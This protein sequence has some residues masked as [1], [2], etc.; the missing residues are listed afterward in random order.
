MLLVVLLLA[1]CTNVAEQTD[2]SKNPNPVNDNSITSEVNNPEFEFIP[3]YKQYFEYISKEPSS[4]KERDEYFLDLVVKPL[5]NEIYGDSLSIYPDELFFSPPYDIEKLEGYLSELENQHTQI[6]GYLKG[7]LERANEHLPGGNYR[8]FLLPFNPDI[9]SSYMNGVQG[10]TLETG[11]IVLQIDPNIYSKTSLSWLVTH[12]YHHA[13]YMNISDY[14]TRDYHLLDHVIMEGKADIFTKI[15]YPDY[16]VPWIEP[17]KPNKSELVLQFITENRGSYDFGNVYKLR[18][19]SFEDGLPTWSN[20][21]ISYQIME[22][23]LTN[24]PDLSIIEWTM[25]TADEIFDQTEL[26]SKD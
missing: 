3:F 24:N 22:K 5:S 1:G 20:Y 13:V 25:M 6:T 19:G 7:A 2:T 9:S 18:L 17:L 4:Q 21:K 14:K 10:F 26:V 11:D 12:E 23:F 8:V 15:L 16:S